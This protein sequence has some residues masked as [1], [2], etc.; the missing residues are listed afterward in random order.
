MK[1]KLIESTLREKY[2]HLDTTKNPWRELKNSYIECGSGWHD[3]IIDLIYKIQE[4]YKAHDVPMDDFKINQ[5][6]EK[7]GG[8]RVYLSI[9][10]ANNIEALV[11]DL[12][13]EYEKRAETVCEECGATGILCMNKG[14]WLQ[15]LC[16]SCAKQS[17]Y[18][19]VKV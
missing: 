1:F 15:T 11:Y 14:K 10:Y 18:K 6:K 19:T 13:E 16:N 12:I 2:L 7:Y 8:L 3:L 9:T 4:V 17:G 5:I